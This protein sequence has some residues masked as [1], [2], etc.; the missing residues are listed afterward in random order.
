MVAFFYLF[1][2]GILGLMTWYSWRYGITPTPTSAK[3]KRQLLQ[4]LP[5]EIKGNFAELGSGWGTL[6]FALA[7]RFPSNQVYAY[8]ISPIP[9]CISKMIAQFLPYRNLHI[10]RKDFFT[11]SLKH[12]SLVICYLYPDAM[13]RLKIKFEEELAQDAYVLSHTFAIP[14]WNP[15]SIIKVSDL[16]QTPIYLYQV[17]QSKP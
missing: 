8:E 15:I 5:L 17:Q 9:Y 6:A 11:I 4:I 1:L 16:Y 7:H 14:G 3:V 2:V 12:V 13:N 10:M